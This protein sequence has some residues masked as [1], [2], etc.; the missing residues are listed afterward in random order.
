MN[1]CRLVLWWS[2]RAR[3]ILRK[4]T[5]ASWWRR[6]A[7]LPNG[8]WALSPTAVNFRKLIGDLQRGTAPRTRI[9]RQNVQFH[10]TFWVC[11]T[12]L[13]KAAGPVHRHILQGEITGYKR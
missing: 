6:W 3:N 9:L 7:S 11:K 1:R 4:S 10:I 5:A 2:R 8:S 13:G 12:W